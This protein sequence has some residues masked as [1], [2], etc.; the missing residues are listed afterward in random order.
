MSRAAAE[1]VVTIRDLD[2]EN[3]H[4]VD[5]LF[6]PDVVRV[7]F[8]ILKHRAQ[9]HGLMQVTGTLDT[10]PANNP[11]A[12]NNRIYAALTMVMAAPEYLIQQ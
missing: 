9:K 8:E 1:P 7:V 6:H 3:V 11:T 4:V 10:M 12:L 5:G 2:G